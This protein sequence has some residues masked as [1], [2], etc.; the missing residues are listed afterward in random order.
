MQI[1]HKRRDI[2]VFVTKSRDG[3]TW[4]AKNYCI[5]TGKRFKGDLK[6][7]GAGFTILHYQDGP[8][9]RKR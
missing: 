3:R 9:G 5:E 1:C 6:S 7:F 4:A 2:A 8:H